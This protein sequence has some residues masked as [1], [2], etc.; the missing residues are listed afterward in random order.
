MLKGVGP[1]SLEEAAL[2]VGLIGVPFEVHEP[3]ELR[4]VLARLGALLSS[5]A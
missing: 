4:E 5:A 2:R 1:N 3:A